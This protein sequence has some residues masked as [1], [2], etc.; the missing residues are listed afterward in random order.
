MKKL[1]V[2]S[3]V[4][5]SLVLL[6]SPAFA[7]DV[8]VEV[9]G[10]AEILNGSTGKTVKDGVD[11]DG[12]DKYAVPNLGTAFS[13]PRIRIGASS[14]IKDGAIGGWLRFDVNNYG[15]GFGETNKYLADNSI[16][17]ELGDIGI[18]YV[19]PSGFVWWKPVDMFKLQIGVNPDGE[20]G[21][22][23]VTGWGFYSLACE[24]IISNDNVWGGGYTGIDSK[25]RNAFYGGFSGAGVILTF[26]PIEDLV[27]NFGIPIDG[28][29][30]YKVYK[31]STAQVAYNIKG[32][33]KAGITFISGSY[34]DDGVFDKDDI[35]TGPNND[36]PEMYAFFGLRAS[37]NLG[38]DFGIGYKFS[39]SYI[40]KEEN[41][42]KTT[43]TTMKANNP[44][45][46]GL[47]VGFKSGTFGL[48]VRLM[49]QFIGST[50][51]KTAVDGVST[52][53]Y[54]LSDGYAVLFDILPSI[55]IGDILTIYMSAGLGIAGGKEI[56]D[57][58]DPSKKVSADSV[59]GWHIQPYIV[60]TPDYSS[61]SFFAGIRLERSVNKDNGGNGGQYL[62]WS[63]PIGITFSF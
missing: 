46:V 45:A 21:L 27:F 60:I 55:D 26:T 10:K 3:A 52:T 62:N 16:P 38:I 24:T 47:G 34:D 35:F 44:L 17:I 14:E 63:I 48:N 51:I 58:T 53:S 43:Q 33:G 22:E 9:F 29:S 36:N 50:D 40:H 12:N 42:G 39:D 54:S 25:F 18:T 5:A 15:Y 13:I 37:E 8:S 31:K 59:I 11:D 28:D 30:A 2:I 49:G 57:P 61:D 4:L 41:S 6:A 56:I 7:A 1:I 23:G 19:T 20:F 32:V